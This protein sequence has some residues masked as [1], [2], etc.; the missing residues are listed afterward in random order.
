M[1]EQVNEILTK[2]GLDFHIDKVPLV[3]QTEF[4]NVHKETPYFGLVNSK[5]GE[6]IH[7]VKKGYVPSQNAEVVEM[8]LKGI[9]K[10]EGK[11]LTVH[12]AGAI[13]G[14]KRIFL[15]LALEG[16]ARVGDDRVK[17]YIT[18]I[19]SND[20]STGLS[21][22][23][24]DFTMSCSNQFFAFYKK[25]KKF[26]H[27]A[28][29]EEKLK[30]LPLQIEEAIAE[31]HRMIETYKHLASTPATKKLADQLVKTLV[32][33]DRL[34]SAEEIAELSTRKK[35]QMDALH[36]MI[37]IEMAQKGDNL[38]GLHSGITRYT[39]HKRSTPKRNN[40]FIESQMM[41]GNAQFN[42]RSLNFVLEHA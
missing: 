32:G 37:N 17:K 39:T 19:D 24:G 30:G 18:V 10:V 9:D 34:A 28:S 5:S 41:G 20:G 40:G 26:R 13:Q 29:L 23:V 35:N 21:V 4:A 36:E 31:S 22:G 11:T 16:I 12:K 2:Y 14:G 15:Q 1:K 3:I 27:S 7:A 33:L 8:V 6:C 38:W 42:M 25:G